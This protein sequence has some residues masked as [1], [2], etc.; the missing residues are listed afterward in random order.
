[1]F[2]SRR[3][4]LKLSCSFVRVIYLMFD[5]LSKLLQYFKSKLRS[6]SKISSN[7]DLGAQ[8]LILE[9]V[10]SVEVNCACSESWYQGCLGYLGH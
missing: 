7:P 9:N 2:D 6:I 3:L 4:C 1:M 8:L 10:L 5:H